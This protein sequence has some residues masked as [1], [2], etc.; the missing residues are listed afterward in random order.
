MLEFIEEFLDKFDIS[1]DEAMR[2]LLS[3][4]SPMNP[5]TIRVNWLRNENFGNDAPSTKEIWTKLKNAD[6]KCSECSSQYRITIDHI[7]GD[8]T[9]HSCQNLRILCFDCNRNH[10]SKPIKNKAHQLRVYY[11]AM[12]HLDEKRRFPT[13]KEIV[14]L[15]DIDQIGGAGYFIK[16]LEFKLMK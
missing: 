8:A 15:A 9:N 10:S 3:A 16:W 6:F 5:G 11:A 2:D 14:D 7:D 4:F 13:N 1:E 12:D